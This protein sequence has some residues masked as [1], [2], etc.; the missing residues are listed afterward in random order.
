M[1]VIGECR[2]RGEQRQA[3]PAE[4]G[5]PT[6]RN[7][8]ERMIVEIVERVVYPHLGAAMGGEGKAAIEHIADPLVVGLGARNDDAIGRAGLDDVA[9]RL[10]RIVVARIRR[11]DQM[12][13][14][15]G[16][17]AR[18]AVDHVGDETHHLFLGVEDEADD[19]GLAG[20][21]AHAGAVRPVADLTGDKLHAAPRLLADLR[22]ILQRTRD[23]G[24]AE[25]GHEGDGLQRRPA[26]AA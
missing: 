8:R 17:M 7:Q 22:R 26:L 10:H 21:Q 20:A 12:V 2:R 19:V 23:G 25:P 14:R 4:R 9:D 11:H 3:P 13:G 1:V 5:Q 24:H 15:L 16:Q 6:H 18:Y